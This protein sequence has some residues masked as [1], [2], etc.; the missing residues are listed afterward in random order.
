MDKQT[1]IEKIKVMAESPSCCPELKQEVQN[2]LRALGTPREKVAAENL[3]DEIKADIVPTEQLVI[4]AH[5]NSAIE[6]FG[7]KRAKQFAAN[8]DELKRR[9]EKY[10]N[11]LACTYGLE[12]LANKNILLD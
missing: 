12:I 3:L 4:F 2:Y 8:A 7:A 6:M 10:C 5:S 11:C 1:L 9:G